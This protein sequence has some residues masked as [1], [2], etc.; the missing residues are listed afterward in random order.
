[1]GHFCVVN[2]R[3]EDS[4]RGAIAAIY[5]PC[6]FTWL[7]GGGGLVGRVTDRGGCVG[8]VPL[9]DRSMISSRPTLTE[10][11]LPFSPSLITSRKRIAFG[12]S[13]ESLGIK[14][15]LLFR[16]TTLQ[17]KYYR[18]CFDLFFIGLRRRRTRRTCNLRRDTWRRAVYTG[19]CR[20][21]RDAPMW[22]SVFRQR[23]WLF[24]AHTYFQVAWHA[25]D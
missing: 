9:A 22:G 12:R 11:G 1:M 5:F 10:G 17:D 19:L 7:F 14:F 4:E 2:T 16:K 13:L 25:G 20:F 24:A 6:P 21:L 15:K 3:L 23:L 18:V 8:A